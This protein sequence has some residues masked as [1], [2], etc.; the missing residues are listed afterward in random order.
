MSGKAKIWKKK[1]A[2]S[3]T[4]TSKIVI[5]DMSFDGGGNMKKITDELAMMYK[6]C[7]LYTMKM[8]IHRMK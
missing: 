1:T 7:K 6:T 3:W 5:I 2:A 8:G 4:L